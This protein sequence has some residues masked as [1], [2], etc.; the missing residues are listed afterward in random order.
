VWDAAEHTLDPSMLSLLQSLGN[1]MVRQRIGTDLSLRYDLAPLLSDD[2]ALHVGTEGND[3]TAHFL[4]EGSLPSSHTNMLEDIRTSFLSHVRT[5]KRETLTFESGFT[6][7]TLAEDT[8]TLQEET[9]TEDGWEIQSV[10]HAES[11][12]ML[13]TA[14]KGDR[15]LLSDSRSAIEARIRHSLGSLSV[16]NIDGTLL[17][18][19]IM[20][21]NNMDT[22]AL[23]SL[24]STWHSVSLPEGL[25]ERILW[26]VSRG[27]NRVVLKLEKPGE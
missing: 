3:G 8:G 12:K 6:S 9:A 7:D 26:S 1:D 25:G 5:A 16:N 27:R 15:V 18:A 2:A 13:V 11:G 23:S 20:D 24:G 19:G 21:R 17:A 14:Q 10:N 4:L 22:L